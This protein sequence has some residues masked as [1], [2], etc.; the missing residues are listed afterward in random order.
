MDRRRFRLLWILLAGLLV[1]IFLKRDGDSGID[2]RTIELDRLNVAWLDGASWQVDGRPV[3]V[4]F[5]ATWCPACKVAIPELRGLAETDALDVV[6]L[7]LD[8]EASKVQGFA[9]KHGM[10]YPLALDKGEFL[11]RFDGANLPHSVLLAADGRVLGV[12]RG[13]V[14]RQ[15]V[16]EDLERFREAL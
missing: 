1:A 13:A 9:E 15:N 14:L 11:G 4:T 5:W 8:S 3:L 7:A 6:G 2:G 16:V 10:A 12:Y